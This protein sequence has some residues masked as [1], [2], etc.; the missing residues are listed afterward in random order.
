VSTIGISA[1]GKTALVTGASRGIGASIARRLAADGFFVW[2]NHPT[3][4]DSAEPVVE[5]IV[6]SGHRARAIRADLAQVS[7]I[8][9]MFEV[10]ERES[11]TLDA[12]VNNAGICPFAEWDAITE[13]VWDRT[14]N[15][16]LRGAYFCTQLAAKL[17][18]ARGAAGRVIAISSISAIK[19][20]TVQTHYCPTKAGLTGMMAAFA[21]CLG[22][23]GITCNSVL[24]GTIETSMSAEYLAVAENRQRLESQTCVGYIGMPG[25]VAAAV[26]FLVREEARYIT[27]CQLLVDG[28]EMVKH[29]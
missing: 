16:N 22:P 4:K 29:L 13:E 23:H 28:G 5:E 14:H 20:G 17:M 11:P 24:P 25:D 21:V 1:N 10:I 27:G 6:K 3:E 12:L 19:G 7:E 15:V 8:R 9:S 26:S 2:L 18:V